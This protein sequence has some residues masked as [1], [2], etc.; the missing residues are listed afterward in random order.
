MNRTQKVILRSNAHVSVMAPMDI[1]GCMAGV[2]LADLCMYIDDRWV[3]TGKV[4]GR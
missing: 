2:A 1:G 4:L 3:R